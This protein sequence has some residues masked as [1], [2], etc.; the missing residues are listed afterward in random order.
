L[1]K[2]LR[3]TPIARH[4]QAWDMHYGIEPPYTVLQTGAVDAA[5]VQRF[6][7]LARYWDLV[8]N[9]GRFTATLEMLLQEPSAFA[10]FLAWSDWL[11]Q[12]TGK[13]HGLTPEDF[14]DALFTYLT[15]ERKQPQ[16]VVRTLL[17]ADYMTSGARAMPQCLRGVLHHRPVLSRPRERVQRQDRHA[18]PT[19]DTTPLVI[20]A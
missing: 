5:T 14:V 15:T 12:T 7:R 3:G 11:W 8:A 10:A 1:L 17:L 6:T 18:L 13:T 4:T 9:S 2:R 19:V 16:D 20:T